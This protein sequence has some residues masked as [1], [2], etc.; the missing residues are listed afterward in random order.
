MAQF[1]KK[2][3]KRMAKTSKTLS[4]RKYPVF[5]TI[6][7]I[8]MTT[9]A[10]LIILPLSWA[11]YSSFKSITEFFRDPLGLPAVLRWENYTKA[12]QSLAIEVTAD[13]GRRLSFNVIGMAANSLWY[14]LLYS[15]I[16]LIGDIISAYGCA[17]YQS[18]W[19]S[20]MYWIVIV[21]MIVPIIGATGS[22]LDCARMMGAYDNV[23][24]AALWNAKPSGGSRFLI[25]YSLFKGIDKAYSEAAFIDGA[26]NWKVF[27]TIMLPMAKNI[28]MVFWVQ[29][30]IGYWNDWNAAYIY[31][32]GNPTIAYGLWRFQRMSR[33]AAEIPMQLA[34]SIMLAIPMI[35]LFAC[36]KDHLIGKISFGGL[37]G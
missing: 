9:F 19:G 20:L 3:I 28:L 30:L 2:A 10:L 18:R 22:S 21:M 35:I 25:C 11:A 33:Y 17:R 24:V 37:K 7:L 23:L 12:F 1:D 8:L 29:S 14:T 32:P 16:P 4:F 5:S 34:C 13:D 15:I 31:F 36:I 26:G 27:L 6:A